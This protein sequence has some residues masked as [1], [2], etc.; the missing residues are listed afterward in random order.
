MRGGESG[1]THSILD[2]QGIE[3]I[4]KWGEG[5]EFRVRQT[6]ET[7][8]RLRALG[9]PAPEIIVASRGNGLRYLVQRMLPGKPGA[10]LTPALLERVVELNRLQEEAAS[11]FVEGWPARI[12]ESVEKGFEKWVCSRLA[13]DPL[14]PDRR[15]V[16]GSETDGLNGRGCAVSH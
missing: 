11:E 7:T 4:L 6:L 16:G 8:R 9:Y 15:L 5:S 13:C 2:D 1:C 12:V 10:P 14:A 3:F